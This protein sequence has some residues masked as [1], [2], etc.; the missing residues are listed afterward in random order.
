VWNIRRR[1]GIAF[2]QSGPVGSDDLIG[3]LRTLLYS[4]IAREWHTGPDL[5]Y[6]AFL[7]KFFG[8]HFRS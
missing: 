8:D 6:V 5:G 2:E 3:I 1:W 4:I 7:A